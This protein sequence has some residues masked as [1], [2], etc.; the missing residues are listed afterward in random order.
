MSNLSI[1]ERRMLI[2]P[3]MTANLSF[4]L[5]EPIFAV[6]IFTLYSQERLIRPKEYSGGQE[7]DCF[8]ISNSPRLCEKDRNG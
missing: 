1:T 3:T 2:S 5:G 4:S 6:C 8:S 7:N